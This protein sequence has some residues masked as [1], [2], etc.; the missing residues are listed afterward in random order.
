MRTLLF[1]TLLISSSVIAQSDRIYKPYQ[2][3]RSSGMGGLRYTT[4]LYDENF[5]GNPA[6]VT[7]NPV[8]RVQLPDPMF[9]VNS[10][11]LSNL[12]SISTI[13]SDPYTFLGNNAGKTIHG[14]V[15]MTF[16]ALYMPDIGHQKRLSLAFGL[17]TSI[18][19]DIMPS[20]SYQLDNDV[21]LDIGPAATIGYRLLS[22]GELSVGLTTHFTYRGSTKSS[23]SLI[24]IF[25]GATLTPS[26]LLGDSAYIDFDIGATYDLPWNWKD[27]TFTTG[28]SLNNIMSGSMRAGLNILSPGSLPKTFPMSVNWGINAYKKSL[29]IFEEA[30][31]A[32]E[33][34]DINNNSGGSIFRLIHIGGE[35]DYGILK[36]RL[37]INQGYLTAGLGMD[38]NALELEF[39]TYGEELALNS[40]KRPDRVYALR[41]NFKI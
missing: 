18:Q 6:R 41:L 30:I 12:S 8:W 36:P 26:S 29:W 10:I 13:G 3:V 9:E 25:Q 23:F 24:S 14:R 15:Q 27:F 33:I 37:G 22:E 40:G 5:Y 4:G 38:L 19:A 39:A 35:V 7:Q 1:F 2:S 17:L 16:P 28:L 11:V 32:L 31:F 21:F 20:N 34:T